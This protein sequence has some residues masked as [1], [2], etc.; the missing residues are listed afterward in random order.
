MMFIGFCVQLERFVAVVRPWIRERGLW[1][2]VAI[3]VVPPELHSAKSRQKNLGFT[4][5]RTGRVDVGG[6]RRIILRRGLRRKPLL[7]VDRIC[8]NTSL[9]PARKC[10]QLIQ[11]RNS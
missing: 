11:L 8:E 2:S 5:N 1:K 9:R 6:D 7:G 4:G 3:D 10:E